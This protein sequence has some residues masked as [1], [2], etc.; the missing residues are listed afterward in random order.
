[1]PVR[2]LKLLGV[3]VLATP[4]ALASIGA[5]AKSKKNPSHAQAKMTDQEVRAKCINDYQR[6]TGSTGPQTAGQVIGN[7]RLY[8]DCVHRY[9][10]RP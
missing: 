9:G 10:V 3:V 2:Y 8:A 7:N 1:M 6:S 4:F 5:D